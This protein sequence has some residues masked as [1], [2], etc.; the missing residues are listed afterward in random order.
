MFGQHRLVVLVDRQAEEF[1]AI[2]RLRSGKLISVGRPA[3][4]DTGAGG[5]KGVVK[6]AD[7]K[8]KAVRDMGEGSFFGEISV[9]SGKPRTATVTATTN[10]EVLILERAT[11]DQICKTHPS[12]RTTLEQLA[13][14]RLKTGK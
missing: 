14:E 1:I 3:T 13:A 5:N 6:Q 12:V 11:L 9:L 2:D 10:V 4:D 7:G 8:R